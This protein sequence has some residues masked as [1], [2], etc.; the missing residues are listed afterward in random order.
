MVLTSAQRQAAAAERAKTSPSVL[1][2]KEQGGYEGAMARR[3]VRSSAPPPP[4]QPAWPRVPGKPTP[5]IG[6]M[7]FP[8]HRHM[9]EWK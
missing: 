2:W 1:R 8:G 6:H 5:A 7:P 3:I 4:W 9:G